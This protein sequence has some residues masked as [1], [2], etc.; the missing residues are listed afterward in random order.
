MRYIRSQL[1]V[2]AAVLENTSLLGGRS[3]TSRPE[4]AT[5]T[6]A[7]QTSFIPRHASQSPLALPTRGCLS[8]TN[9]PV[10]TYYLPASNDARRW[11]AGFPAAR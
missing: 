7:A 5:Q 6:P 8:P 9:Y 11:R 4:P 3:A 10:S 1:I 2:E